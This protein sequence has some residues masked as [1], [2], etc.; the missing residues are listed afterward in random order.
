MA[1]LTV[2]VS[3]PEFDCREAERGYCESRD[4]YALQNL[5]WTWTCHE[6]FVRC[7]FNSM[8]KFTVSNQRDLLSCGI[9]P[10]DKYTVSH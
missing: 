8:I 3:G 4:I 2:S 5:P 6:P 10:F 9:L 7:L 1:G